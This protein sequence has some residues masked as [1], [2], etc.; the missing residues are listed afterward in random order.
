MQIV[1]KCIRDGEVSHSPHEGHDVARHRASHGFQG[2]GP[3]AGEHGDVN[4][5][6]LRSIGSGDQ[7]P[8]G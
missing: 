2:G 6:A 4:F 3:P 5:D 8:H 7:G 1:E